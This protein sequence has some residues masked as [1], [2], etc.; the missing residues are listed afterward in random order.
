MNQKQDIKNR[1]NSNTVD[2][3]AISFY[4]KED[5]L[6]LVGRVICFKQFWKGLRDFFCGILKTLFI[7]IKKRIYSNKNWDINNYINCLTDDI[8]SIFVLFMKNGNILAV[9]Y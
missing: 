3:T 6:D 7:N 8:P 9:F 1:I 4:T 2:A 5:I